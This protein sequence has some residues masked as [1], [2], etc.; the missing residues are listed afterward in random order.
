MTTANSWSQ[1]LDSF[2]ERRLPWLLPLVTIV[3]C[4]A[5]VWQSSSTMLIA[6]PSQGVP[7][8]RPSFPTVVADQTANDMRMTTAEADET[9]SALAASE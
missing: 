4:A 2:V 6:E 8:R 7:S 1:T 5:V 3:A 9:P